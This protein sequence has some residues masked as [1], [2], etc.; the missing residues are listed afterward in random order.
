MKIEINGMEPEVLHNFKG[1][2]KDTVARMYFD[3]S[4]RIMKGLLTPGAT[5]GMHTH[6]TSSE[7]ILITKGCG[8]V[9][10]DGERIPLATGDVHYC[11]KGHAHSLVNDSD[12]DMEFFA[13]VPQQ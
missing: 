4:N 1:G 10:Y 2:E 12:R 3:G 5:I 8:C 6:D 13:V 9:L 7:T 11:P